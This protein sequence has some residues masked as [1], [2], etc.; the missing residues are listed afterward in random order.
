MG[1]QTDAWQPTAGEL[2][3]IREFHAGTRPTDRK[4]ADIAYHFAV[5]RAGRVWQARPLAYQGA[6]VHGH[7]GHNLGIVLLGNFQ[8]QSPSAAQLTALMAFIDFTRRLYKIPLNQIFTHGE[9]GQTDCPGQLLQA[10][11]D[12]T[13]ARWAS[14]EGIAWHPTTRPAGTQTSNGSGA[15]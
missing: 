8:I 12:R 11:M 4:W 14:L 13:R 3:T 9:L 15:L 1:L 6:H 5:D 7:N 10:F 2:E